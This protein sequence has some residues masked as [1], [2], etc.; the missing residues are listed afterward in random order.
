M[1]AFCIKVRTATA[2]TAFFAIGRSS[3]A[4][5]QAAESHFDEPCGITVRVRAKAVDPYEGLRG[6]NYIAARGLNL[7]VARLVPDASC[8]ETGKQLPPQHQAI[9]LP[10]TQKQRSA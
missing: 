8:I 5:Q 3:A 6:H 2:F 4:A 7:P 9:V 10:F 1:K